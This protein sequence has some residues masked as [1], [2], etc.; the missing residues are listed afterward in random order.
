MK[1]FMKLIRG[2]VEVLY[3]PEIKELSEDKQKSKNTQKQGHSNGSGAGSATPPINS[4]PLTT[5][6][7]SSMRR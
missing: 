7:T 2:M 5:S 4:N 1:A 6:H 3:Y